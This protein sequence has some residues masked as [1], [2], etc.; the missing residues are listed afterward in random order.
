MGN[1]RKI[2]VAFD[3]SESGKNALKQALMLAEL[4]K[5]WI[6]VLAVVPAYEGDLELVGVSEIEKVLKGPRDKLIGMA[7]E[8]ARAEGVEV[9]ADV[10]QGEPY[11]TIVDVGEEESCD[12]I[13]MG[14]RGLRRLERM[15]MGSVTAR[16]IGH[17]AKDVLVVP[18]NAT[19]ALD[20]ILLA[21][22]GS[23]HSEAALE[24]ALHFASLCGGKLTAVSVVD[25]YPEFYAE[26]PEIVE[27][28]E[29]KSLDIIDG[30]AEKAKG[31]GVKAET[32]VL[33]GNSAEEIVDLSQEIR[34]GAIF[35]GSR[36]RSGLSKLVM[37][38]VAEKVIGLASCPVLV[39]KPS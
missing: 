20:N 13:V 8:A 30:V 36:G 7:Q 12:L 26:A 6:K 15:L 21:T 39:A 17:S 31:A 14:R 11:E 1:Y 19:F 28:M 27:K 18:R 5:S 23:A 22:D 38:S 37:G 33:R 2:L 9:I 24:R 34:A 35:M 10:Q 16:V 29:K 3:G 32:R 25:V 4:E